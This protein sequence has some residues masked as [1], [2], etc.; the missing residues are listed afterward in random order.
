MYKPEL[1]VEICLQIMRGYDNVVSTYLI[2]IISSD[3]ENQRIDF[4]IV[5]KSM[6]H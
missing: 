3:Q 6:S 4:N 1:E 5:G 2:P